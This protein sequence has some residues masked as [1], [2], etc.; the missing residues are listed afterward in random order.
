MML[1][2]TGLPALSGEEIDWELRPVTDVEDE[3]PLVVA[4][5]EA[6]S[7]RTL[8]QEAL[9]RLHEQH[10]QLQRLSDDRD[11]LRAEYRV[12]RGQALQGAKC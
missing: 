3:H 8:A 10:L 12:L 4:I 5:L 1:S 7:F 11:R 9:H 2:A 6:A